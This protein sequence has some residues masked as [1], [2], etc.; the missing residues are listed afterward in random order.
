VPAFV[1]RTEPLGRLT[2]A[3][4]AV[5]QPSGAVP[6]R[7]PGLVLVTGEAGIG[8]TA[9]VQ[10]FADRVAG[11][12]DTVVWGT[13]WDG[14]QVPAWWP[15]TQAL[16]A[17]LEQRGGLSQATR[18]E[19]AAIVPE[20]SSNPSGQDMGT[21]VAARAR[22]FDAVGQALRRA[23]DRPVVVVLE[24]LHWADR[25][26]VDL[27]RFL[28][29]QHRHGALLF[30]GTYRPDESPPDIAA[31]LADLAVGAELVPLQ[32]LTSDEVAQLVQTL[33][34]SPAPDTARLVHERSA[35][36]PFYARE[37]CRL[38][39]TTGS[40]TDV[41]A[42]VREVIGRRLARLSPAC[43][44]LLEAA[45]VVGGPVRPDVL[46]EVTGE[47]PIQVATLSAEA[48]AA[49]ILGPHGLVHDLYRETI[50]TAISPQQRLELH[51]RVARA[52]LHRQERGS[53]VFAAELAFHFTAALPSVE[54]ALA[55]YW[56][57]SAAGSDASRFAFAEAAG[58]L[59]RLRAAVADA[60]TSM[61]DADLVSVLT[62]EADLWLRAGDPTRARE[63]LARAWIRATADGGADLLGTV[64]LGLDRVDARFAMP[65]T[66][67]IGVL[68]TA[69]RA[70]T[71]TGTTLEASVTAALARQLQHSVPADRPRARPLADDAVR[72]ARA[73]DDPATLATCLLA[74]HD[75]WWTPGT[76]TARASIATEIADLARHA[77]D[78]ERRAQA[79]LLLATAQ[80]E[81]ASPAFRATFTEFAYLA[82]HLR[83]PRHDYVL[84]TRE[85]ALALLDGDID[86][87]NRQ[88]TEA[89][90]LGDSIGDTDAGNVRMSQRLEIVRARDQNVELRAMAAEA[91]SWWV[92]A[93]AHA[94]AVAAGFL[95]RAGD[96]DTARR[97]LDIVLELD[98]WRTDR[99]YLW[100]IFVGEMAEAAIAVRDLELCEQL[101]DDLLPLAETCA[102]NAALV[103]FMGAHAHRIGLLHAALDRPEYARYWLNRAAEIHRRLGARAW[104]AETERA[105]ASLGEPESA[106]AVRLRQVG[107]MW[108]A[109][110]HGS[111]VFLR[112]TKGLHDLAVLIASPGADLAAVTL[113]GGEGLEGAAAEPML[114]RAAL[115]AYRRRLAELDDELAAANEHA[116]L[117]RHRRAADEREQLLVELRRATRPGGV[118]R[119]L[120]SS[121]AERARKA[122]TARIRDAIHRIAETHPELGAHLD[123][124]VRTGTTCSYSPS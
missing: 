68:D 67:L 65:R 47:D 99:S 121:T 59:T 87:G 40:A 64:A 83:Q 44:A 86:G 77:D 51:R 5:A 107:D 9:L 58:H 74:Q 113:A 15:W 14:D 23:S 50:Y 70:L 49:G 2:A 31:A 12:G 110:Y 6:S 112:D 102:V 26:T 103:C 35:G 111:T 25:S 56:A 90:A 95:A 54:A 27:L 48:T 118:P 4:R 55:T 72:L 30:V 16:R 1:G 106:P 45:A 105:L 114:D 32:G 18:P 80:L 61:S 108:Q 46:A 89:A 122:V 85:A 88:S 11:D 7:W 34:G 66:D 53:P 36:H 75:T 82:Q 124:S 41:P 63:L 96:L 117:A 17:L 19:L 3:Y 104:E 116:D 81:N 28:S 21:D 101:L 39:A 94:H 76:A 119:G 73:L 115:H 37:L 10:Q 69:R 100:S 22:V 60:G 13:C 52:L 24:D 109:S 57:R 98:D 84:R 78:L 42:A 20:V 43:T 38:L 79:L 33:T 91:V 62:Q 123:R 97:E 92:G 120:A 8:K 29:Q 93:P 71:G